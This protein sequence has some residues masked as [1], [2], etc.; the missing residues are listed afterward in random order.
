[1]PYNSELTG[2]EDLDWARRALE[3]GRK[4][5]YSARAE[6]IHVHNE[7]FE[8]ILN[9][10]RR[11]AIAYKRIY[12]NEKFTLIDFATLFTANVASDLCHAW[13]DKAV[14]R[15]LTGIILFRFMQ[16]WGTYRGYNQRGFVTQ[17][18]SN[19]F[20]YPHGFSKSSEPVIQARERLVNYD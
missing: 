15:H 9:R 12:P 18:L 4:I 3:S 16:F 11:E 1:L 7:S 17:E 14:F 8:Q 20:Y 2:L 13:R 10:Y 5:I 6:I 19:R